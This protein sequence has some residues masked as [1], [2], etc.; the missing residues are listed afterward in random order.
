M[1]E[2]GVCLICGDGVLSSG[3]HANEQ[4]HEKS[5]A[6]ITRS[7]ERQYRAV[8]PVR[9]DGGTDEDMSRLGSESDAQS[10]ADFVNSRL[11]T[12]GLPETARVEYREVFVTEWTP[13]EV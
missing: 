8:Y 12:S 2:D 1:I 6:T 11:K 7:V 3:E 4:K 5:L 9:L 10:M 13:K